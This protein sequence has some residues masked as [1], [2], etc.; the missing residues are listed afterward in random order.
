MN[1]LPWR[2]AWGSRRNVCLVQRREWPAWRKTTTTWRRNWWSWWPRWVTGR[3][4]MLPGEGRERVGVVTRTLKTSWIQ[5]SQSGDPLLGLVDGVD[6]WFFISNQCCFISLGW[7]VEKSILPIYC[8]LL[9]SR[10]IL[11][12][13][14][15][16]VHYMVCYILWLTFSRSKQDLRTG[17]HE[18]RKGLVLHEN[19]SLNWIVTGEQQRR[20]EL[21]CYSIRAYIGERKCQ[22]M[23]VSKMD[24]QKSQTLEEV[25]CLVR[26]W[27]CW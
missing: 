25:C 13:K 18:S 7:Q 27:M 5:S 6:F 2:R 22:K 9:P 19:V 4:T 8:F 24:E 17:M 3:P 20:K 10:W 14:S 16:S 11:E 1:L 26:D 15:V 21:I 23:P 12:V